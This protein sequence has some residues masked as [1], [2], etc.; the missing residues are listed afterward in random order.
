VSAPASIAPLVSVVIPTRHRPALLMRAL[1]SVFAQT[2]GPLEVI[3]V[4]DGPDDATVAALADIG[5]RRLR[6]I[7]NPRSLT[8]AGARNAGVD[9]ATGDWVAFLDDDDEWLP[10]KI[11]EQMALAVGCGE[12]LITCLSRV[13]SPRGTAI[14]PQIAYDNTTPI[15][16]Y[17][18]DRPSPAMAV[19]FIQTSSYLLRR[20]LFDK[21]RF[22]LDNPHDDWDFLLRLCKLSG[23]RVETVPKVLAV[24]HVDEDR[25][26]LSAGGSWRASLRWI[27]SV[28]MLLTPRAYAGFCLGV[29][30]S[31]AAGERAYA[32]LPAV[33]YRAFR[34]GS[35]RLWQACMFVARWL[36]PLQFLPRLRTRLP[37]R[38][39]DAPPACREPVPAS[40]PASARRIGPA[41][42]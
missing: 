29:A 1:A 6:V 26:S 24:L 33:L 20:S 5:D 13:V 12:A 7:V 30:G 41:R 3:V 25:P 36:L 9:R 18:F 31:R 32:G 23:A 17:L 38:S 27:D 22:R 8:A 19:G 4:V 21:V 14:Q 37:A 42:E 15:D 35:P 34:Y 40:N 16:E 11:A 2:Y 10:E 28:R 39:A